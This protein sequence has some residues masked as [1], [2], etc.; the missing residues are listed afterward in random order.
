M[1][2]LQKVNDIHD[3][4]NKA[5]NLKHQSGEGILDKYVNQ[6]ISRICKN[7]DLLGPGFHNRKSAK[8]ISP[9]GTYSSAKCFTLSVPRD[10]TE[11][12]GFG[13]A[14]PDFDFRF[15]DDDFPKSD[16]EEVEPVIETRNTTAASGTERDRRSDANPSNWQAYKNGK[17]A[18]KFTR[19]MP[20]ALKSVP[21]KKRKNIDEVMDDSI[22][23]R[24][25]IAKPRSSIEIAEAKIKF[26][27]NLVELGIYSTDE[28]KAMI[29]FQFKESDRGSG[30][31]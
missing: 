23:E 2:V 29:A 24:T 11:D 30:L 26:T 31:I 14:Q 17:K 21:Q 16:E 7:W 10:S 18:S 9:T 20:L 4:F 27:K 12:E 19:D 5:M 28:V 8:S 6:A 13:R 25:S 22:C 15:G 3:S 1:S